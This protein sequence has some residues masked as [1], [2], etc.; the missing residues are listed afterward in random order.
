MSEIRNINPYTTQKISE[1]IGNIQCE[2][3]HVLNNI[4]FKGYTDPSYE[5][6]VMALG[7]DGWIKLRNIPPADIKWTDVNNT[8]V[9]ITTDP[10]EILRLTIDQ[11]I[12]ANNGNAEIFGSLD[13]N[14]NATITVTLTF[15]INGTEKSTREITLEKNEKNVTFLYNE[16]F[17]EDRVSGDLFTVE[18]HASNTDVQLRG[19]ITASVL[20]VYKY[21]SN[22]V[23][24]QTTGLGASISR[25]E[26]DNLISV[27]N[28]NKV[29][30]I[31][32]DDILWLVYY[33]AV[34]DKYAVKK[35]N[36]K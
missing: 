30:F 9:D 33:I 3:S 22:N 24:L 25:N 36:L 28:N 17:T 26:I 6:L 8:L 16:V 27:P 12:I 18:I 13:N 15:K 35:L 10:Q 2:S 5:D 21:Q 19:D 23:I 1:Y 32:S 34:V 29:Y 4:Q 20:S 7:P 11:N 31:I 14:R